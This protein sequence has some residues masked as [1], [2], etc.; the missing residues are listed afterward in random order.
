MQALKPAAPDSA[1]GF[2]GD[3]WVTEGDWVGRYGRQYAVLYGIQ[4]G[5]GM[6][7]ELVADPSVH[8]DNQTGPHVVDGYRGGFY[9]IHTDRVDDPRV[10]YDPRLGYRRMA[11]WNDGSFNATKYPNTFDGPDLWLTVTVPAGPH[12]ISLYFLNYDGHDGDNRR[13]DYSLELKRGTWTDAATGVT[14]TVTLDDAE[15]APDL[16]RTRVPD[17]WE[18]VWKRFIVQGPGDYYVKVGRNYS[19]VTKL[20]AVTVD[21]ITGPNGTQSALPEMGGVRYDPPAYDPAALT[22][23]APG[24]ATVKAAQALWSA[25]DGATSL[26]NGA[27]YVGPGRVLAYRAARAA[28]G[29]SLLLANW[30]WALHLWPPVERATFDATMAQAWKAQHP[31]TPAGAPAPAK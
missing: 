5:N 6:D 4:A 3:D 7:D 26:Y 21:K 16:A 22:A 23:T 14:H 1:G 20:Q 8:V 25:L 17:F 29:P 30:R 9:Y 11:E 10:P 15:K 18:G 12:Q 24:Y 13:R 31:D 27:S 28:D 19:A 2:L